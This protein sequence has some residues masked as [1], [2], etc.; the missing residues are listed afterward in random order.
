[1]MEGLFDAFGN[2]P[3]FIE[4]MQE[5]ADNAVL[6]INND[7]KYGNLDINH[8]VVGATLLMIIRRGTA[9]FEFLR[10]INLVLNG[11]DETAYANVTDFINKLEV[12]YIK[13]ED[14][15]EKTLNKTFGG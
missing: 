4:I 2:D 5:M 9:G 7:L 1:M 12:I 3:Q 15:K 13:A 6:D 10:T 8:Q 11:S 14:D